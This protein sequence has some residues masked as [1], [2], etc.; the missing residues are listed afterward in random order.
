[1]MT[2]LPSFFALRVN[3]PYGSNPLRIIIYNNCDYFKSIQAKTLMQ[4]AIYFS[5]ALWYNIDAAPGETL[6]EKGQAVIWMT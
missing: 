3:L 1:M 2:Q 6:Y 5:G 4:N